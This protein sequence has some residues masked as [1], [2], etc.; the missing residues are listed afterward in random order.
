[1]RSAEITIFVILANVI[2]L[3]LIAGII[4]FVFQYR[5]R[6]ILHEKEKLL[7][8]EKHK[9]DLLHTQV[10]AQEQTMQFIGRE[11]HDSVAQ[12]LTLATI[13]T[14]KLEY[15]N[16]APAINDNLKRISSVINDSLEEL[17]DLSRTLADNKMHETKLTDLLFFECGRVNDTGICKAVLEADVKQE[18]SVTVKS[19]LLRIVQE[20]MQN[21]LKHAEGDLITIKVEDTADGLRLFAADNGKGFNSS[22]MQSRGI[23]LGNMKRRVHLIGGIFNLQSE[24]GKGTRLEISIPQKSLVP[25]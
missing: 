2:L 15:E 14:Q 17:R 7:I 9:L 19:F 21:S 24:P 10:Q 25:V 23:G 16:K 11:I 22:N 12:K 5:K 6:K 1:M 8:E 4:I 20:F 13:Y 18:I 3:I